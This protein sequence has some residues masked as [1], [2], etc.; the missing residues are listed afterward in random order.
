[1]VPRFHLLVSK[2][3][4]LNKN[5]ERPEKNASRKA[6]GKQTVDSFDLKKFGYLKEDKKRYEM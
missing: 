1:M 3:H 6:S 2:S 5:D 4:L